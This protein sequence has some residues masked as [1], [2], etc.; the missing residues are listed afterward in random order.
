MNIV[1][2]RCNPFSDFGGM[3]KWSYALA[4]ALSNQDVVLFITGEGIFSIKNRKKTVVKK[5]KTSNTIHAICKV[6][7]HTYKTIKAN[8]INTL[9]LFGHVG[10]P[11]LYLQNNLISKS[12]FYGLGYECVF[13]KDKGILKKIKNTVHRFLMRITLLKINRLYTLEKGQVDKIASYFK[14]DKAKIGTLENFIDNRNIKQIPNFKEGR[15]KVVLSIGRDCAAKR[16]DKLIRDWIAYYKNEND[17]E[18]VIISQNL[19]ANLLKKIKGVNNIKYL[20][21]ISDK[22]LNK[23]RSESS[24]DVSYSNQSTPLLTSL[25]SISYGCI[26][27][28]SKNNDTGFFNDKNSITLQDLSNISI[29]RLNKVFEN[30]HSIIKDRTI[31]SFE[32]KV[33]NEL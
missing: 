31:S 12:S 22:E 17:F 13:N 28:I 26:P 9:H 10:I 14:L 15:K 8:Q 4:N 19:K 1:S 32:Q 23:I 20:S 18:L 11:S 33:L 24:F 6:G 7:F 3:E 16:R 2:T 27:I 21:N 25:E 5:F 30:A 29:E